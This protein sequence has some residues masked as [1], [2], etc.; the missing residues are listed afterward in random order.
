M[1]EKKK[2]TETGDAL[3]KAIEDAAIKAFAS[4]KKNRSYG[5]FHHFMSQ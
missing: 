5:D 4:D 2:V 3:V 1:M